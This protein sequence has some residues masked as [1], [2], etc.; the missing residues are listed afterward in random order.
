MYKL[1]IHFLHDHVAPLTSNHDDSV[2]SNFT[3]KDILESFSDDVCQ[4]VHEES[5]DDISILNND[6]KQYKKLKSNNN[7]ILP[8][9]FDITDPDN[10]IYAPSVIKKNNWNCVFQQSMDSIKC[11]QSR[12][13]FLF[14]SGG[15]LL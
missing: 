13:G 11:H 5:D 8:H 15:L 14:E 2:N 12:N 10:Y 1:R 3:K 7:I 4:F 6:T 9:S